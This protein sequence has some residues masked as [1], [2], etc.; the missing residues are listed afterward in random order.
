MA[1]PEAGKWKEAIVEEM[2]SLLQNKTWHLVDLQ[3][4]R[5]AIGNRWVFKMKTK[6]NL[7]IDRY[8]ARLVVKGFTQ[9]YG[10]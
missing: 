4:N 2:K 10:H 5:R 6:A 9:K 1:S 7:D 3:K 8:K